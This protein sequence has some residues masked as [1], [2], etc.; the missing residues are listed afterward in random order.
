ML[1]IYRFHHYDTARAICGFAMNLTHAKLRVE[2]IPCTD[3][4][5]EPAGDWVI[6]TDDERYTESIQSLQSAVEMAIQMAL[7]DALRQQLHGN[8][9]PNTHPLLKIWHLR[10]ENYETV[11]SNFRTTLKW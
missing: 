7:A 11:A 6:V 3:T 4:R 5:A 10:L 8:C 2:D 9:D 1:E